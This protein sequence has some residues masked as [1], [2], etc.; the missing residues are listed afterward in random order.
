[1]WTV[2]DTR[3]RIELHVEHWRDSG[4]EL[5]VFHVE[6]SERSQHTP[7][8]EGKHLS[9]VSRGTLWGTSVSIYACRSPTKRNRCKERGIEIGSFHNHP[10]IFFISSTSRPLTQRI[11]CPAA[12][13]S[14]WAQP[15]NLSNSP[16]AR[17][18][19]K[20]SGATSS[21]SSSYWL[22]STRVSVRPS[23]RTTSARNVAFLT[24]DSI[25]NTWSCGRAIFTAK[26]GKPPP[27]PT[28]ASRPA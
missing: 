5:A 16:N 12:T 10:L 20:S 25:K 19:T 15:R 7:G 22:T 26:P 18:Q 24:F 23:S 27:D 21:P 4:G 9:F 17:E 1:M 8:H 28:S 13:R 11:A 3:L 2:Q 6:Q 14:E